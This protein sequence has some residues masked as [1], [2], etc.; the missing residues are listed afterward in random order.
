[1]GMV[2]VALLAASA[3]ALPVVTIKSTLRRTTPSQAQVG[4]RFSFC[5]SVL[6]DN[7]LSFNPSEFA[8][9]L[10]ERVHVNRATASA[11]IQETY[12]E[13]FSRL[14]RLGGCTKS[15]EHSA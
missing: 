6:D 10:P 1:M 13:D 8:Q 11:S 3:G 14:L 5:K 7:I 2:V 15:K 9:L 4:G 12:A